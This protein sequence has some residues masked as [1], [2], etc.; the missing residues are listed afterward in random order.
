MPEVSK[1]EFARSLG[2]TAPRVSQ[3][4]K[5]GLPVLASGKVDLEIATRWV[6]E[7]HHHVDRFGDRGSARAKQNVKL[8]VS[9]VKSPPPP[10]LNSSGDHAA[11]LLGALG[12]LLRASGPI[13][14]EMAIEAG[15]SLK[16]AYALETMIPIELSK[17]ALRLLPISARQEADDSD[18]PWEDGAKSTD[19]DWSAIV[20]KAGEPFDEDVLAAY[21]DA[22]PWSKAPHVG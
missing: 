7:N 6:S 2:V 13:V 20:A 10:P 18:W 17:A 4:V 9:P 8:K 1:A 11:A 14:A 19:P 16:I 3:Y 5:R 15:A 12:K 21:L 22:L